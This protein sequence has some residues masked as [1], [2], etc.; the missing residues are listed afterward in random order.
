MNYSSFHDE[1][2]DTKHISTKSQLNDFIKYSPV[3]KDMVKEI[4]IMLS[5]IHI[6]LEN[7]GAI[8]DHQVLDQLSGSAKTLRVMLDIRGH[9]LTNL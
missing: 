7:D 6:Q 8:H 9:V 1:G 5:D 4:N 3:W 2:I